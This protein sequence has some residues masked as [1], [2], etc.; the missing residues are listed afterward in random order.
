MNIKP[1]D[2]QVALNRAGDA[3]NVQNQLNQK[4][5]LDQSQAM[6]T[7]VRHQEEARKRASSTDEPDKANIK[8]EDGQ[9]SAKQQ[10]QSSAVTTAAEQDEE[11]APHPYKGKHIDFTL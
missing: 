11:H 2:L 7:A 6:N 1:I 8:D 10:H 4:P 9:P 3:G 5:Q